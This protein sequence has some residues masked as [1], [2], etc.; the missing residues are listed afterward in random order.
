MNI[1]YIFFKSIKHN[2]IYYIMSKSILQIPN[3]IS[4]NKKIYEFRNPSILYFP[5]V[6]D[7]FDVYSEEESIE[8][9]LW[10]KVK[11]IENLCT[12]YGYIVFIDSIIKYGKG[13][14]ENV[15]F[16]CSVVYPVWIKAHVLKPNYG[17]II[18]GN[19]IT[20]IKSSGDIFSVNLN[21]ID[22]KTYK[23]SDG[24]E[25]TKNIYNTRSLIPSA[26]IKDKNRYVKGDIVNIH[27]GDGQ[28]NLSLKKIDISGVIV[29][30]YNPH[31]KHRYVAFDNRNSFTNMN[32]ELKQDKEGAKINYSF[33]D[34]MKV[35]NK[36]VKYVKST[37]FLGKKWE[38]GLRLILNPFEFINTRDIYYKDYKKYYNR[39]NFKI[40]EN[41]VS[42]AYFKVVE[43][44]RLFFGSV[45]DKKLLVSIGDAPGGF[46]QAMSHMY[47]NNNI[48]T[49]SLTLGSESKNTKAGIPNYAEEVK[50]NKKIIIDYMIEN[51]GDIT[52]VK[53]IESFYKNMIKKFKRKAFIVAGDAAFDFSIYP[54]KEKETV[55]LRLLTSE[56]IMGTI[57]QEVV[58]Y[59]CYLYKPLSSRIANTET[60]II[61]KGFKGIE[62]SK[63]NK[64]MKI[65]KDMDE[66]KFPT[67]I[68]SGN[69]PYDFES[70]IRLF[71]KGLLN[72]RRF[73]Y[74]QA[75]D[76]VE[77]IKN[78]INFDKNIY[79]K[80][81]EN[82]MEEYIKIINRE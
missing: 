47:P 23:N 5:I 54:T 82:F 25:I 73:V 80:E 10:K 36:L 45:E 13:V 9:I 24:K 68:F 77:N 27:I 65:V 33:V 20:N 48:L 57:L 8:D 16:N 43:I 18:T 62:N 70:R 4:Y 55:H 15:M 42:R 74:E 21:N 69:I 75:L 22:K 81:Q 44:I 51:D 58:V 49:T 28:Y 79:I 31:F 56:I 76:M 19:I 46:A 17:S 11:K 67:N 53:N 59:A 37:T 29:N 14:I 41:P 6:L 50:N 38:F 52:K 34:E 32:I 12:K 64:L 78:G 35:Y 30:I 3:I 71:N 39:Y 63:V 60:F 1:L 40:R 26:T 2:N 72:I 66:K 7:V 61:C